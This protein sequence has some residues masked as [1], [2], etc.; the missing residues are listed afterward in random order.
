MPLRN[1]L[2]P[3]IVLLLGSAGCID[4]KTAQR[5]VE[6]IASAERPDVLPVVL[7]RDL[8]FRYPSDLY[9]QKVQG[10][11]TLWIH[12]D[13]FGN[14]HPDSTRIVEPSGYPALDS[15]AVTGSRELTF[16]PATKEGKPVAVSLNFPVFF[17]HPD[18]AP[19]PGDTVLR[20]GARS[21]APAPPAR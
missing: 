15:A 12:I 21:N 17:R 4:Q 3:A 9:A 5:A 19:L 8:P 1:V 7:N 14:V 10:N 20:R 2:R 18:A 11:V 16:K 6:A 13:Q